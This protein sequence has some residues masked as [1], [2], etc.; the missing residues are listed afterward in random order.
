LGTAAD[1]A[2]ILEAVARTAYIT[3]TINEAAQPIDSA[4]HDKHYLRKHG[5]KAY[6]G[7]LRG[8]K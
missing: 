7:Q 5:N 6:Y 1:N 2:V 4:L 8:E 3:M